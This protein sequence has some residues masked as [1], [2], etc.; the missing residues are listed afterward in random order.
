MT[1]TSNPVLYS[2][3]RCPYAMRARMAIKVSNYAVE[4]REVVLRDKPAEMIAASPKATVPV[5]IEANGEVIDQS[6]DIMLHVLHQNDPDNWLKAD[7]RDDL[8]TKA[9]MLALIE[10]IDGT[11]KAHL[12][13]YKYAPRNAPQGSEVKRQA[14]EH[15]DFALA[16][17]ASK[18]ESR[19]T[20]QDFLF[21]NRLTIADIAIA[22]F[23]RQF[24]NTDIDWFNNQPHKDLQAWPMDQ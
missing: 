20:N 13:A 7:A 23:V 24:A 12:D 9:A 4:L 22:P 15:R 1:Q 14:E 3:R 5:L 2:F 19:L 21:G 16:I 6:F 18:I 8:N 10:E 17:L 11:F